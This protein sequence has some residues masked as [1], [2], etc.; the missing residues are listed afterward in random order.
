MIPTHPFGSTGH[1]STRILFGAAALAAMRQD[2]ADATL[3]MLLEY[4]VNHID[5][6]AS[7]GASEERLRP[8]LAQ[9]R[10]AF[11][12]ATKT[13]DRTRETARE[14]L[15][16]SLER[17]GVDRVDMIQ[18]HNLVEDDE[19]E[20]ALGPDGAL[21]ALIEAR[22]EGL[23]RFIGVTG[24]GTR[25]AA[26]HAR[27]LERFAFDSVLLPCNHAMLV[28]PDYA[29]D[30]DALLATC[31]SRGIAVQTIKSIARR[32]WQED[33]TGPRFSWYEPLRDP[34]AI[35]RAVH[36]VLARPGLFLNTS[37]DATLLRATLDAASVQ[38]EAPAAE[39]LERDTE[40]FAIQPLFGEGMRET[41]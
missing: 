11:F 17:M 26:M 40:A 37:S 23:V 14:S 5:T 36:F 2:R 9:H 20:T 41:I 24:H 15:H 1:E 22:D 38:A 4:G 6:A 34:E 28:Q 39:S 35:R 32:R 3:E 7:Y 12:L 33:H 8:F 18:L 29:R 21:E 31:V 27:S 13:G 25:I 10:D 16:R 19:W 30:F